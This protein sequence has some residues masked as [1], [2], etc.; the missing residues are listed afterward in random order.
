[1]FDEVGYWSEIKLDII[2]K[3]S[4]AYSKAFSGINSH[5]LHHVYVDAFA[6]SGTHISK[7]THNKIKGSPQ[8][9]LDTKPPFKEYYFIDINGDKVEELQKLVVHRPEAHVFEGDCNKILLTDVFPKLN[10]NNTEEGFAY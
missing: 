7:A 1:L 5:Y 2:E 10:G 9:A 3:Y 4:V 6:G 8:I